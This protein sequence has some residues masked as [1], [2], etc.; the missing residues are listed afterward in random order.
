MWAVRCMH[1]SQLHDKNCFLTLTYNDEN[2]PTIPCIDMETGEIL[3]T[4]QPSLNKRDI[5][6]FMKD[7][8][9]RFGAGIRFFQCGEYGEKFA[10]PHHHMILFGFDFPDKK[11]WCVKRGSVV[12]RDWE[13]DRKSVV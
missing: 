10:R 6:L 3:E 13:T 4:R 2:L 7:L 1:E 12:Y 9:K 11:Y 8:R 5:C